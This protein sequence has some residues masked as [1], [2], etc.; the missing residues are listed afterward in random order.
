MEKSSSFRPVSC[1]K[2]I[3]SEAFMKS[4]QP[5][6]RLWPTFML[7]VSTQQEGW[8]GK[9]KNALLKLLMLPVQRGARL[10]RLGL[11][12]GPGVGQEPHCPPSCPS[13]EQVPIRPRWGLSPTEDKEA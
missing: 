8:N 6:I 7:T 3:S 4:N 5:V 13:G 2:V 10:T 12:G 11:Y 9:G 1:L